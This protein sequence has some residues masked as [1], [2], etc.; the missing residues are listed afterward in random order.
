MFNPPPFL[1]IALLKLSP[2]LGVKTQTG[3]AERGIHF[4]A[5]SRSINFLTFAHDHSLF[6]T[7]LHPAFGVSLKHLSI[8]RRH[9]HETV[10]RIVKGWTG[11]LTGRRAGPHLHPLLPVRLRIRRCSHTKQNRE[12]GGDRY[13]V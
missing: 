9:G 13:K 3:I 4:A 1:Q 6:G 12:P 2:S 10:P 7:H 5:D 8:L 11:A